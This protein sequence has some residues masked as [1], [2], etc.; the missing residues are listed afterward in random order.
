MRNAIGRPVPSQRWWIFVLNPPRGRPTAWS[1][2]SAQS[3]LVIRR[4]PL[5]SRQEP[6]PVPV[7]DALHDL[8]VVPERAA[9]LAVGAGQQRL[10]AGPL[11]IGKN[12][13]TLLIARNVSGRY[14]TVA[15]A[16]GQK[17]RIAGDGLDLLK[18]Q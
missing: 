10:N 11:I 9:T 2:G 4:V 8:S 13:E 1:S 7:S 14:T 16:M 3:F 17:P 15:P 18:V 12:L 5:R 6:A